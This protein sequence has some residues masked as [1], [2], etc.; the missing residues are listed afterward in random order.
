[1]KIPIAL[2]CGP[3]GV[4]KDTLS[5]YLAQY[6]G[7]VCIAQADPLKR[8]GLEVFGFTEDQLW[9]A[10]ESRN[11]PDHRYDDAGA[12]EDASDRLYEY[13]PEWIHNA[14]PDLDEE[15]VEEAYNRLWDWFLQV[16]Q[17][18][19]FGFDSDFTKL[20]G[21]HKPLTARYVLQSLGTEYG[22]DNLGETVWNDYAIRLAKKLLGGGWRYDRAAGLTA[23]DKGA[24]AP[25]FV[26]LT[27]GRFRNEIL[28]VLAESGFTIRVEGPTAVDTIGGAGIA[29]H[30]SEAELG[31][32]PPH[33]FSYRLVNDK[34]A[35]LVA[36][37][38]A[39]QRLAKA[40]AAAPMTFTTV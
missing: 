3:A 7:G 17:D 22:R 24:A 27:D 5:N 1:M 4:G 15:A 29:G 36:L 23:A 18:H 8:F 38:N 25:A 6:C 40:L 11:A 39:A 28:G 37:E 34:S 19:G 2:I 21:K 20:P 13:G 12:W 30:R 10:S 33:F 35:G 9:G 32:M 26:F 16:A 31:G 14:R